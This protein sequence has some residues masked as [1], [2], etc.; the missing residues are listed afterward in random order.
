MMRVQSLFKCGVILLSSALVAMAPLTPSAAP[1]SIDSQGATSRS[2]AGTF[3]T[4]QAANG[5]KMFKQVCSPCHN[6]DQMT[7]S[8]FRSRWAD[9]TV[10][11]VF[12]FIS[13][14]MPEGN[15]GSLS[16]EEYSSIVAFFLRESGYEAGTS[17]LPATLEPLKAL[18]IEAPLK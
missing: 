18:R 5:E 16:A 1:Q 14:A 7:G 9:E 6:T 15:P 11:D 8:K 10:G 3:S 4:Q 2:P 13:S 12:D 17:D